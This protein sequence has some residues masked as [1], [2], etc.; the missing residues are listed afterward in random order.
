ML[1]EVRCRSAAISFEI[2]GSALRMT[3]R[4]TGS[5]AASLTLASIA[6]PPASQAGIIARS[7]GGESLR[8]LGQGAREV[9]GVA[10]GRAVEAPLEPVTLHVRLELDAADEVA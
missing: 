4:V 10:G 1:Y 7:G 9:D 3:S 8:G 5:S 6:S 2:A